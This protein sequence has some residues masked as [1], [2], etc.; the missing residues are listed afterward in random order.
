MNF[1]FVCCM[2]FFFNIG[3]QITEYKSTGHSNK[4]KPSYICS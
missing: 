2:D 1:F 4:G 3:K